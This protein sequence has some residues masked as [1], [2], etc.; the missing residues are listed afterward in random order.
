MQGMWHS[1]L[2]WA[3]KNTLV[4]WLGIILPDLLGIM[5]TH[6]RETYQPTS[7]MRW[8][9]GIFNGSIVTSSLS[10]HS[11]TAVPKQVHQGQQVEQQLLPYDSCSCKSTC[12]FS[13]CLTQRKLK[14]PVHLPDQYLACDIV[15]TNKLVKS[16]QALHVL[17]PSH[18]HS[19]PRLHSICPVEYVIQLGHHPQVRCKLPVASTSQ[20]LTH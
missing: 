4:N 12:N 11:S 7:I 13:K 18:H 5:I 8:D 19:P 1:G 17:E 20:S 16:Q 2:N 3:I 14:W 15:G 9:M 6:N 10:S